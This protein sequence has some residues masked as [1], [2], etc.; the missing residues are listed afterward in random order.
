MA[1]RLVRQF[2]APKRG[3]RQA[4]ASPSR[5]IG[6]QAP[7]MDGNRAGATEFNLVVRRNDSLS[8]EGRNLVLVTLAAM[9]LAISIGFAAAGAWLVAPFAGVEIALVFLAF[10]HLERHAGDYESVRVEGEQIVIERVTAG[11]VR[12]FEFDRHWV[13]LIV[14]E[15]RD[16]QGARLALRAHGQEVEFGACLTGEQRKMAARRLRNHLGIR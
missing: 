12:K 15:P 13:Q 4:M 9:A 3:N 16:V 6:K 11:R 10:R 8:S 5:G 14:R 1:S 7:D 2:A